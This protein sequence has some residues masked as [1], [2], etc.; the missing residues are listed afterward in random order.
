MREGGGRD[1]G[2]LSHPWKTKNNCM[3]WQDGSASEGACSQA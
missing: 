2:S 3:G 1:K